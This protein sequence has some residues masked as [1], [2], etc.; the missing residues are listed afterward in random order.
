MALCAFENQ[1]IFSTS[2]WKSIRHTNSW[3]TSAGLTG[4]NHIQEAKADTAWCR[5]HGYISW[6]MFSECRQAGNSQLLQHVTQG[7]YSFCPIFKIR[8]RQLMSSLRIQYM[9]S[10]VSLSCGVKKTIETM[11]DHATFWHCTNFELFRVKECVWS[12][13]QWPRVQKQLTSKPFC[14]L[15]KTPVC[16]VSEKHMRHP[17]WLANLLP[18]MTK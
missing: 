10:T 15:K 6:Q 9:N 2:R 5:A 4:I 16:L 13:A 3:R 11:L 18:I 1:S 8:T 17:G 14:G 12:W 7:S